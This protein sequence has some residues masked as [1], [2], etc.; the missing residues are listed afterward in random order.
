MVLRFGRPDGL[1]THQSSN[2][3]TFA[4]SYYGF[5]EGLAKEVVCDAGDVVI[6]TEALTHGTMAWTAE[7]QRRVC[8]FRY[9]AANMA[10]SGGRHPYDNE[11]RTGNAWPDGWYR[12]LTDAQRAVLEPPYHGPSFTQR[13]FLGDDGQLDERSQ[14]V[15]A[16]MGWDELGGN[17]S[18]EETRPRCVCRSILGLVGLC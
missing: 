10:Y 2:A 13:P 11:H 6:F 3:A 7:T 18:Y 17:L 15:V 14:R 1:Y 9:N 5:Q 8:H 4:E 16:E 12:G